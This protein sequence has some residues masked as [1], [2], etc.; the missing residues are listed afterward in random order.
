MRGVGF[1]QRL[2]AIL[3]RG[4]EKMAD[5]RGFPAAGHEARWAWQSDF[6]PSGAG[7]RPD[8]QESEPDSPPA[9]ARKSS[10]FAVN[11]GS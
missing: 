9:K 7:N 1:G 2:F 10:S 6:Q 11:G 4:D 5:F 8:S 3:F